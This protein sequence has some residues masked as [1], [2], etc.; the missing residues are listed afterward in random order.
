LGTDT[1]TAQPKSR[2][3]WEYTGVWGNYRNIE[4]GDLMI[5]AKVSP[6]GAAQWDITTS[7]VNPPVTIPANGGSFPYNIN[8]HNLTTGPLPM[9]IWNKVRDVANNYILVF[10]PISRTLPGGANPTRVL[11][12]NI[13]GTIP[14]GLL[15]FIS[16]IGT[17]PN[18]VADS[19]FFTITKSTVAD[20]SPWISENSVSGDVFDEYATTPEAV[21]D[22]F[23]LNQNYP[24]PFNPSTSISFTLPEVSQVRLTVFD[25]TGR[26]VA[27]LVNGMRNAGT[28]SVTFDASGLASGIYLYKLEAGS[29]SSIQKMVLMK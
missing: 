9:S 19:S 15:Y 1:T 27:V 10:G 22:Q 12:Q 18:G 23:S 2:Q 28:H 25:V 4:V 20:G 29:F 17:Y 21:P 8:V 26:E 3:G 11:N 13:A 6:P 7:A 14:S 24:N 5:R 16:Y